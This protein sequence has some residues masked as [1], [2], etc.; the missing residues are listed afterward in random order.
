MAEHGEPDTVTALARLAARARRRRDRGHDR[1]GARPI[2]DCWDCADFA[3]VPL[4]WCAAAL[5]ATCSAPRSAPASTPP[6]PATA[7]GWTSPATTCSGTSRRTTRCCSTPPPTSPGTCCRRRA[8]PA[9]AGPAPSSPP[10]V[11]DRVRA[12][13]DHFERWEMAEFNSAPYF[14]IDLKGLC[15]LFA[16]APDADIA[17]AAPAAASPGWSRSSPIPRTGAC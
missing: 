15:A 7:T 12:W 16:L 8:S 14:P 9:R 10:S 5:R 3:L 2:D 11:R 4:L 13:L 6:S 1:G 17:A